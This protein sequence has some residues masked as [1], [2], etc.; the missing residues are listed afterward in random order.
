MEKRLENRQDEFVDAVED[1]V[2]SLSDRQEDAL[3]KYVAGLPDEAAARL[4]A[5]ERRV[6][7][8]A[9]VFRKHPGLQAIR[10]AL[11]KEWKDR[12]DWGPHARPPQARRAEGRQ[13]LLFVDGLLNAEQKD[14]GSQHLHELHDKVK[15][16]LGVAGS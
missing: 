10:D 14:H 12:E 5:D 15:T 9:A 13:A 11:W 2:G 8:V 7:T 1:W 16:F 3:R 4:A 6:A